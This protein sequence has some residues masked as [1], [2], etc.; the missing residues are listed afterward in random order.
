M[1]RVRLVLVL[2]IVGFIFVLTPLFAGGQNEAAKAKSTVAF[3]LYMYSTDY[4][5]IWEGIVSDFQKS[6]PNI[7]VN[8]E[9]L[10]LGVLK[11]KVVTEWRAGAGPDVVLSVPEDTI[12]MYALGFVENLSSRFKGWSDAAN[13]Y[14]WALSAVTVEGD[15]PNGFVHAVPIDATMRALVY[16][17]D[18]AQKYGFSTPPQTWDEL[19]KMALAITQGE[20]G[21]VSGFGFCSGQNVRT[22]QEFNVLLWQLGADIAKKVNGKWQIAFTEQDAARNSSGMVV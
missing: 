19:K 4:K 13:F 3:S 12:D 2:M 18:L 8:M 5:P 7:T 20:G 21:N 14:P 10:D 15:Y 1:K 9:V 16:R 17:K 22:P 11:D 6:N